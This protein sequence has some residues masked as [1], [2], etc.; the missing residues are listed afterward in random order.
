MIDEVES[1]M[2]RLPDLVPPASLAAHVMARV[3]RLPDGRSLVLP[4]TRT[5][6]V[7]TESRTRERLAW[8]SG[9]A[10]LVIA[11]GACIHREVTT[12]TLP[13]L[14]SLHVGHV[15]LVTMP[16]EPVMLVLALGLV[17]YLQG[18]FS[19]VRRAATKDRGAAAG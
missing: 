19:P 13:D 16:I 8:V 12:G 17:L 3:A 10:G 18:L 11:L 15:Q 2:T 1:K 9:L 7:G 14:T 6:R 5:S 4:A